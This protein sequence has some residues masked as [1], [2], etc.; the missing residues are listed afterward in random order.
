MNVKSIR[1]LGYYHEV[2]VELLPVDDIFEKVQIDLTENG[3]RYI[4][5]ATRLLSKYIE[6]RVL[7]KAEAYNVQKF[8]YE[9]IGSGS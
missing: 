8:I 4:I 6:M 2:V 3:N 5:I 9:D 7:P 1:L